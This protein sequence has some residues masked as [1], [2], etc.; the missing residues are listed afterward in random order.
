ML[1]SMYEVRIGL[2]DAMGFE[3]GGSCVDLVT[4]AHSLQTTAI[5]RWHD[6]SYAHFYQLLQKYIRVC[7]NYYLHSSRYCIKT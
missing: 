6:C 3:S 2:F 5:V 1:D 7:M 4:R